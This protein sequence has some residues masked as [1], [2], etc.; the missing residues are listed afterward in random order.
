LLTKRL[1]VLPLALA[2]AFG[3]H[4]ATTTKYLIISENANKQIG[5]QV[6]ERHDDGLTK[7]LSATR[8]M[9][10]ARIWKSSSA[11]APTAP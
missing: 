8:T 7:V 1:A 6:V 2:A 4:A 11:W 9:A 5:Q 10:A 3:A